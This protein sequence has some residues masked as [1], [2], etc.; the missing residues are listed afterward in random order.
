MASK[1]SEVQT[2][3]SLDYPQKSLFAKCM[4]FLCPTITVMKCA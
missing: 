4:N 1:A 2:N 3:K